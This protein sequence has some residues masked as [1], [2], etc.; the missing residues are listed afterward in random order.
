MQQRRFIQLLLLVA[1][2]LVVFLCYA[3]STT[4]SQQPVVLAHA[5]VIGSDPV[6]GSTVN[7]APKVVRIFFDA[8]IGAASMAN[9]F[10]PDE[11]IVNAAHS[12]IASSNA[13]E[14]D[15]PLRSP[16]SLPQGSY[17]VRW[18]ALSSIDGHTT[19]GVIG[20]NVGQSSTGLPGETILGPSTSNTLPVLDFMGILAV[21]W[22]WLV[23]MA[24]T[25]WVGILVSEG[26]ILHGVERTENLLAHA[27]KRAQPLQ[28]LCLT[29]LLVG[30]IITLILH[31]TQL[32]QA[33]NGSGITVA[34]LSQILTQT[35]YGYFWLLR[36]ALIA[37]AMGLLWW[38]TRQRGYANLLRRSRSR[39]KL[40][41]MRQRV[42]HELS[43]TKTGPLT[44]ES[45]AQQRSLSRHYR[46]TLLVLAG[47]I[48]LT[49]ALTAD[50][51]QVGQPHVSAIIFDWLYLTARCIWLGGLTYLGY[52][53]LP[54]LAVVEPDHNAEVL[55][56]LLR[57]YH[58]WMLGAVGVLLVTGFYEGESSL[59]NAQQWLGDPY[60][61]TLLVEWVLIA[62]MI[63]L[64]GVALFILRPKLTRQAVLLPVVNAE[65]PMR[66]ARQSALGQTAHRLKLILTVVSWLG[67][68]VLLCAALMAFF[69]PPIVFPNIDY[70][71]SAQAVPNAPAATSTT[72][73]QQV[74]DLAITLQ[75]LPG[76]PGSTNTVIVTMTNTK[77]GHLVTN[78]QVQM[79]INMQLMDMGT[80]QA[81]LK[82]GDPRYIVTFNSQTTFTMPGLWNISLRI[83][84][85][86][87][88]P[89]QAVFTVNIAGP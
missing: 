20:F 86:G 10:T 18:T 59:S 88:M 84:Q 26:F 31:T 74:E 56:T 34:V 23:L 36:L 82:G 83:Q 4:V 46:I 49:F 12:S 81:S 85:P 71:Q 80:V 72:Q 44:E 77:D 65:L 87:Q 39:S 1:L 29:G 9:V 54:L 41:Q 19:Q 57:R 51:A 16:T 22:E 61:R 67:A 50:A 33:L 21:A 17:T 11:H 8:P 7:V 63:L 28:W 79:S 38:A 3:W 43:P 55:T 89:Q 69:A 14:L 25:F 37:C 35:I 78:A 6:D 60:G 75:V 48:L 13:R 66:R 58:P 68:A 32:A 2:N 24:L 47:L 40:G 62:A 64:S 53:L 70:K 27:R 15:T 45:V 5:F 30:E 76:R 42:T 73:T 52:V